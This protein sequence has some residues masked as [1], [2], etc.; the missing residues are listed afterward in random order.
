MALW[1]II[2]NYLGLTVY[3]HEVTVRV[4]CAC[5]TNSLLGNSMQIRDWVPASN[6]M[7]RVSKKGGPETTCVSGKAED[8]GR[9]KALAVLWYPLTLC[10]KEAKNIDGNIGNASISC[11]G[12]HVMKN[13]NRQCA[14]A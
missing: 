9:S 13:G 5:E 7:C 12:E 2:L 3:V 10:W 1:K 11:Y 6:Y 14:R 4:Q 8:D